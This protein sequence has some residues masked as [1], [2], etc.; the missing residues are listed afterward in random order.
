MKAGLMIYLRRLVADPPTFQDKRL[1]VYP[2]YLKEMR[3]TILKIT[4]RRGKGLKVEMW[5]TEYENKLL[6]LEFYTRLGKFLF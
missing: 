3:S 2:E 6:K 5:S 1:G 4:L